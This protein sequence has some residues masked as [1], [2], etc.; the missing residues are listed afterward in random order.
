MET[1][2]Q[3]LGLGQNEK[4]VYLCLIRTGGCSAP[5]LGRELG[6]PRQTVYSILQKLV[7]DGFIEQGDSKGIKQF[8]ADPNQLLNLVE[9]RKILLDKGKKTLE[10][11]I[12]KILQRTKN[13]SFPKVQY[14][15]GEVGLKKLFD[16]VL[17]IYKKGGPKEYR[18]YGINNITGVMSGYVEHFIKERSKFNVQTK[19]FIGRGID[20]FGITG[21]RNSL[22]RD[23]KHL[24]I[25]PQ[26]AGFYIVAN[27]L[28]LFSF[29]DNV[30]VMIENP[31][32][33][34]LFRDIFD[35]QW[36]QA[37]S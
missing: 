24:N 21:S 23:V 18:G 17:D 15:D 31:A 34:K 19:L 3:Q 12:P 14:Y 4:S 26:K 8:Y 30:G 10:E 28:Y 16:S 37:K 9:K 33:V 7:G 36:E 13:R 29:E 35:L 1:V 25:D 6:L 22:G 20:D 11:E 2:L 32:I 27:R 5:Q